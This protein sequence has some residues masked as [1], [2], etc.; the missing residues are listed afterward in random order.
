MSKDRKKAAI[1]AYKERKLAAGIYAVRCSATGQVWVGSTPT[2]D[3]TQNRI[4]F[5]LRH[6]GSPFPAMQQSWNEHGSDSFSFEK[7]EQ[8]S[9]EESGYVLSS[10]LEERAQYWTEKLGALAA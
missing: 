1:A 2:L 10:R 5:S 3:S 9:E 7:L 4:W 8:L 6:G